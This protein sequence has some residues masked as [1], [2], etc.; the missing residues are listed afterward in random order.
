MKRF[1]SLGRIAIA[2]LA[3]AALPSEPAAAFPSYGT[4]VDS[5][6]TSHQRT[7]P[8]PYNGDCAICH[9]PSSS[10]SNRT[11]L[12]TAYKANDLDAF[13]PAAPANQPPVLAPIGSQSVSEEGLL[14]L[15]VAASDPDGDAIALVASGLPTGAVFTDQGGGAGQLVWMPSFAQAGNYSVTFKATDDGV[16]PASDLETITITVGNVNRPPVLALIGDQT[17]FAGDALSLALSATD[18]DGNALLFGAAGL[19]TGATLADHHDGTATLA[20]T[21][22]ANESGSFAVTLTV[23]DDGVPMASDAESFA[24]TLGS[25]NRPPVLDPIGERTAAPGEPWS[26]GLGASDPDGDALAFACEGAPSAASFVDGGDGT[27]LLSSTGGDAPGN[28]ATSC[29]VTDAGTPPA[30]DAETFTLSIGLVNRPPTLDPVG[31]TRE[32]AW[33]FVRLTAH[34]PDGDALRFAATGLPGGAEFLD[35]RDGT[36]ELSWLP[37]SGTAGEYPVAFR[38][39]D[40]GVP[41]ETASA[42][43]TIQL[44]AGPPATAAPVLRRAAWNGKRGMLGVLGSGAPR[45]ASVEILDAASGLPFATAT[46]DRRGRFQSWV[47]VDASTAPCAVQARVGELVSEARRVDGAP[48]RCRPA[49]PAHSGRHDRVKKVLEQLLDRKRNPDHEEED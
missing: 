35:H 24:I 46:A 34:D 3:A 43:L 12:F 32:G 36:A 40:D 37:G 27:A 41:P 25:G 19:P 16:P 23:T 42:E 8:Q 33:I 22:G 9:N 11:V 2:L 5:Y 17:L 15:A 6:C 48:M 29:R 39:T 38:V 14:N 45:G 18:P 4:A 44:A 31:V 10:S 26:V 47:H 13:C 1:P 7:P 49:E 28:Y 20:W 21:T 30:S